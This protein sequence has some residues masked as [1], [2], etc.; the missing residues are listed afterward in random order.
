[1]TDLYEKITEAREFLD[2]SFTE[3]PEIGIILGTG[4]GGL[5]EKVEVMKS[6]PYEDIPHFPISTVESHKGE[7]ILGSLSGK[8]VLIMSGRFHYY[9][10][11]SMKDIE[12]LPGRRNLL[13]QVSL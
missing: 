1:M 2:Q 7:L 11:Y 10:G 8:W 3:K 6:I 9:E 12:E 4:L 13:F 5:I